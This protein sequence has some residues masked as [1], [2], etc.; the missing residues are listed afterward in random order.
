MVYEENEPRKAVR[1]GFSPIGFLWKWFWRIIGIALFLF[2]IAIMLSLFIKDQP[3]ITYF[4]NEVTDPLLN[5]GVGNYAKLFISYLGIPFS[6]KKQ[7]EVLASYEWKSNIDEN[8]KK[9]DFGV[10]IINFRPTNKIIDITSPERFESFKETGAVA[11]GYAYF[12]EQTQIE[13]SCLTENGIGEV[14]NKN[15]ILQVSENRKES[16]PIRCIYPKD[17]FEID[18]NKATDSQ[19]I[20][21]RA[22]YDFIT[23]S[24]IPIYLLKNNILEEKKQSNENIFENVQDPNLNEQDGTASSVYTKGPVKLILRSLY[25]Q[26]YTEEGPFSQGS[27]YTLDMKMDDDISWTGNVEKINELDILMPQEIDIISENFEYSA[28]EDNFKIYKAK[29][30]LIQ[31]LNDL[32]K[33]AKQ[34]ILKELIDEDC[35]RRGNIVTSIEFSINDAPDELS[36]TFIRAK[37]KYKFSDEKQDTITFLNTA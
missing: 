17:S 27:Y 11:E 9:Q 15:N 34:S 6:E 25:T 21:I 26:P 16:F 35:W 8:S 14:A 10:K 1:T 22:S 13:L 2:I 37:V 23:E 29:D 30:S 32:C 3:L 4:Y 31:E 12:T 20:K 28:E 33:P 5:T 36:K 24:Y 7:A 18:T 19:K